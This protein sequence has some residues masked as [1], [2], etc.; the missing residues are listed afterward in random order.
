MAGEARGAKTCSQ[1][2]MVGVA[3]EDGLAPVNEK[4]A[5]QESE[6]TMHELDLISEDSVISAA[7]ST[8]ILI[9]S[10]FDKLVLA[11]NPSSASITSFNS[12]WLSGQGS[13]A[14]RGNILHWCMAAQHFVS[15]ELPE[16]DAEVHD[17]ITDQM[18]SM[19][20]QLQVQ[21]HNLYGQDDEYV[22]FLNDLTQHP[23][24]SPERLLTWI[25]D[26]FDPER[27]SKTQLLAH[28]AAS[29]LSLILFEEIGSSALL[30]AANPFIAPYEPATTTD[31][32]VA[33]SFEL[34]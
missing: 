3:S 4:L 16:L 25:G 8:D 21:C 26:A 1:K 19:Y 18:A 23:D 14:T 31:S 29:G 2:V 28:L 24:R 10:I 33:S 32:T 34:W 22:V 15:E 6:T 9:R 5:D 12:S 13:A 30:T 7:S 20:S 27:S 11:E 17:R